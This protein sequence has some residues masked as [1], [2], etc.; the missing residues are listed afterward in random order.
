MKLT[1]DALIIRENNNIGE[2]DRFVTAL[3]RECGVIQASVRGARRVKNP[4]G[5][6]TQLLCYSRLS[7]YRGRDKYI[8]DDAEPLEVFF[9]VR[10][11]L[12]TLA[13]AQYFCELAGV[14][15]PREEPAEDGLRVLL[16]AL[17]Y[18]SKGTRPVS[19]IKAVVEMRLLCQA[20]YAPDLTA[21]A[22]CSAEEAAWFSPVKGTLLCEACREAAAIPLSAGVLSAMRHI[23]YAPPQKWFAF[24]LSDEGLAALEHVCERFLLAQV[25][26]GFRTLEFYRTLS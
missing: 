6:A 17:H 18:L 14:L 2:A 5:P 19:L 20:G 26:R 22:A 25:D 10:G 9:G 7:L 16:G 8:V 12:E 21:C 3:T 1:T 24:S 15:C 13:L 23:V 4:N 11:Q